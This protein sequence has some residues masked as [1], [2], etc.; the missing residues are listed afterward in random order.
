M[1]GMVA[2]GKEEG[3]LMCGKGACFKSGT[4]RYTEDVSNN[5]NNDNKSVD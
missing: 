3:V 5:S 4:P 2:A 1:T